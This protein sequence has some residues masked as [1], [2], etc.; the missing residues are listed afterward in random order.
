MLA[1]GICA[2]WIYRK[3]A[4]ERGRASGGDPRPPL[5]LTAHAPSRPPKAASAAPKLPPTCARSVGSKASSRRICAWRG[6]GR[7]RCDVGPVGRP[8]ALG[9]TTR[10]LPGLCHPET[11][12]FPDPHR[13]ANAR[14]APEPAP[15]GVSLCSRS[16][17]SSPRRTLNTKRLLR[18]VAPDKGAKSPQKVPKAFS[19]IS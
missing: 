1:F 15:A 9:R 19:A 8:G 11:H 3:L 14:V 4:P 2:A 12:G 13:C 17:A 7:Q 18:R 10:E 6:L 16:A 5:E